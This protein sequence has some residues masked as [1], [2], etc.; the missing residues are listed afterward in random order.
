MFNRVIETLKAKLGIGKQ[1]GF[2]EDIEDVNEGI[3]DRVDNNN[4]LVGQIKV[5]AVIL[6]GIIIGILVLIN[7]LQ[8]KVVARA[9][10]PKSEE[11]KIDLPDKVVDGEKMWRNHYEDELKKTSDELKERL[12]SAENLSKQTRDEMIAETKKEID[13]LKEQLKM[14]RFELAG[15]TG[16]LAQVAAREEERLSSAPLHQEPALDIED[17]GDDMEFDIPKSAKDYVP[18]G[19]YFTGYLMGGIVVS[20][21]LN[22]PDEN[23][24]PLTIRLKGR[25]NLALENDTDISKCRIMGSAYGDLSSERAVIRLE[26]LICEK[27]GMYETSSIVGDV[28]GPDGFNG[29][30]GEVIATSSKHIKN[31]FVGGILSGLGNSAKGQDAVNITTGGLVSAPKKGFKEVAHGGLLSGASNAG[32][33]I[34]DY[35]LRQAEAMSPVL[36]IPGGVRV[37]AHI[38]KGFFMGEVGTH[39]RLASQRIKNNTR[40]VKAQ[41]KKQEDGSDDDWR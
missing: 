31:A 10:A 37:N 19:T 9:E 2:D 29:I 33:K 4:I 13:D 6:I 34:A 23:A 7:F 15:A 26:K 20:T 24:T 17:F 16:S 32:E 14:A 5:L 27:N 18:E 40:S 8:K 39:K 35:Y 25:G 21:A 36:T 12:D 30:K 3:I 22:T 41:N 1:A 11:L 38:T 28:H